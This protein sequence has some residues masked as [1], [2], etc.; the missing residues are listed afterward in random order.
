MKAVGII[1]C[2]YAS[3]RLP[4]KVLADICG[5]PM[6]WHVYLRASQA[7]ALDAVYVASADD[8]I[9]Q[10]SEQLGLRT[11]KT[12]GRHRTGTDCVAEAADMMPAD[13]Y[14]NV[15]G[16]EPMVDPEAIGTVVDA[17]ADCSSGDVIF[18][19]AW[20]PLTEPA[21]VL[22]TNVVK[23][24]IGHN[25]TALWFS[26]VPIPCPKA[27][28]PIYR[29][30]LGLYAFTAASLKKFAE[31]EPRPVERAEE[32]EM[33]RCIEYGWPVVMVETQS[34]APSVDTQADLERVRE[35]M[36]QQPPTQ[37]QGGVR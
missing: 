37:A 16:D 28:A 13:I 32:I 24:V 29:R 22:D 9:L 25:G 1:P 14:V 15:Q 5:R 33:L 23:V 30:Q 7:S 34:S 31:A 8:H 12:S 4:G 27:E 18:A 26:R 35:L 6:L 19:N 10:I 36:M 3:S 11:L 17:L 21:T 2:R 20:A